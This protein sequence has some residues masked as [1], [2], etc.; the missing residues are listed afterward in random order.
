MGVSIQLEGQM[1]WFTY[2]D[3]QVADAKITEAVRDEWEE[4]YDGYEMKWSFTNPKVATGDG[5][6]DAACILG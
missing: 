1:Y 4:K 3:E 2:L 6:I 5:N